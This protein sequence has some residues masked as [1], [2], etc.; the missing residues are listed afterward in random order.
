MYYIRWDPRWW[1]LE[2]ALRN[3]SQIPFNTTGYWP[4]S[5]NTGAK[6]Y[7]GKVHDAGSYVTDPATQTGDWSSL[8]LDGLPEGTIAF[9]DNPSVTR[10]YSLPNYELWG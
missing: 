5:G 8:D 4:Y 10:N 3:G 6:G 1:T 2:A 7:T 9:F